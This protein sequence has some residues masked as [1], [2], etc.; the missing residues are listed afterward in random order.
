MY[1]VKITSKLKYKYSQWSFLWNINFIALYK[2]HLY[3][4][5]NAVFAT[6]I[7][8]NKNR[9]YRPIFQCTENCKKKKTDL[10]SPESCNLI[11]CS[12]EK[13]VLFSF[14]L[15]ALL[16]SRSPVYSDGFMSCFLSK[17]DSK[18]P[19]YQACRVRCRNVGSVMRF[20]YIPP[21]PQQ[22]CHLCNKT[23]AKEYIPQ[24]QQQY[25]VLIN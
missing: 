19:V 9:R 5:Y 15:L 7:L 12:I 14:R 23:F 13:S 25:S 17:I 22:N 11:G 20:V 6:K 1:I 4:F 24:N 21:P 8:K 10:Y 16:S 3:R 2:T 18:N